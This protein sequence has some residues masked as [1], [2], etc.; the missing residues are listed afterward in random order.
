MAI[1]YRILDSVAEFEAVV[2]L[3]IRIWELSPRDAVPSSLLHA[4]AHNGGLIMGAYDG[5]KIVGM[6]LMFP[7]SGNRT[8]RLWSHMAG[9]D[10]AF[11]GQ[12]IGFGIKQYQRNW[13]LQNG[14]SE[15]AWTFD[16]LQR[17]NANFNLHVL[18]ATTNCYYLNYYG[19]MTDGINAGLPSDR[20]EA[21]WRLKNPLV[22][23]R[24]RSLEHS[25]NHKA[26]KISDS[27]LLLENLNSIPNLH[28]INTEQKEYLVEIPQNINSIKHQ[29]VESALTWRLNLRYALQSAFDAGY[30]ARDFV[31]IDDR[32]FYVLTAAE[33]WYLYVV[34][35]A[36]LSFYTGI[37]SD[38][39]KRLDKHNRGQGA[40]YTR[41]RRPV[42]L[43]GS[44]EYPNKQEASKAEN[45]FKKLT[46]AA[47]VKHIEGQLDFYHASFSTID[48]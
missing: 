45:A 32:Y 44:W 7:T 3:E 15:I 25:V 28:K 46:R 35:C 12:G 8:R 31:S 38:I 4:I 11:Q 26:L 19:T 41:S 48:T 42:Q 24:G 1:I 17:G 34:E 36:D 47:K 20:V 6:A 9:V 37:T 29:S 14:Y 21:I 23:K 13:A 40:I 2:D 22:K 33:K 39:Q 16:P 10:P 30:V 5:D 43:C 18:G 27:N